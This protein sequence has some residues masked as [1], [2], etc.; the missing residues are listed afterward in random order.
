M[1]ILPGIGS[2]LFIAC[3][4]IPPAATAQSVDILAGTAPTGIYVETSYEGN[5]GRENCDWY[6]PATELVEA[7][8]SESGEFGEDCRINIRLRG[9]LNRKGARRFLTL[10]AQ[11]GK[12]E[13]RPAAIVLDSRGGDADAALAIARA[14]RSEELFQRE[15]GDVGTRIAAGESAVCFSACIVIFAAGYHRSAEF[16]IYDNPSLPSRLGIHGPGQFDRSRGSYDT[17]AENREIN[18]IKLAFKAF[19]ESVDV[20]PALV[21]DMFAVPFDELRLL[22][23]ADVRRYGLN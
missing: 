17:S 20:S 3:T 13:L 16:N 6:A 5:D 4:L 19:F 8:Q 14:I 23:E 2:S 21:D 11:I 9:T 10:V 18:R 7:L 12:T 1:Q 22:T 15:P